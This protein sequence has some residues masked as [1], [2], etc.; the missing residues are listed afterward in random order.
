MDRKLICLD[1][2]IL[3]DYFR[4]KNKRKTFFFELTKDYEFTVS[5]ITKLE[6]FSGANDE[7]QEFWKQAFR[8]FQIL[9]LGE[10][11]VDE[12]TRIIKTLRSQNQIIELPDILIGATAKTHNLE[13]ATLNEKHFDRIKDLRLILR[14][15]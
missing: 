3:I 8:R 12:A 13:L 10:N 6:I 1:T 9:P 2:S 14:R 7:Q 11:E 5:V 15:V 4:K